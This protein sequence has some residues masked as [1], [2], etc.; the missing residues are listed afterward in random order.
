VGREKYIEKGEWR[1]K[2]DLTT[3]RIVLGE[4]IKNVMK[5]MEQGQIPFIK[6]I[7]SQLL[8]DVRSNVYVTKFEEVK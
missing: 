2:F 6:S 7:V 4:D 8:K 1:P 3:N 5:S